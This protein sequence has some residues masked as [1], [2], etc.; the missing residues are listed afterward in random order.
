MDE[1]KK[2]I[3]V[4]ITQKDMQY[5]LSQGIDYRYE[6]V[7]YSWESFCQAI[8][9]KIEHIYTTVLDAVHPEFYLNGY[10]IIVISQGRHIKFSELLENQ[11]PKR[12]RD[13]RLGHNWHKML[14]NGEWSDYI[15]TSFLKR[16]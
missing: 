3:F 8:N 16:R 13:L 14:L 12:N 6:R 1:I 15:K 4:C 7:C 11:D 9:K 10:D 2:V 5:F